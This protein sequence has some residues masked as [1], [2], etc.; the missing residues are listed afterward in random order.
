MF[1][2]NGWDSPTTLPSVPSATTLALAIDSPQNLLPVTHD[3]YNKPETRFCSGKPTF[4][5]FIGNS[6]LMY[7][8]RKALDVDKLCHLPAMLSHQHFANPTH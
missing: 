6:V 4:M 3:I 8:L 1:R 2:S 7:M 5:R